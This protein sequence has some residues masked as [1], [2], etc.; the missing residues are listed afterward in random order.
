MA[1]VMEFNHMYSFPSL[2]V[3]CMG[4]GFRVMHVQSS[5]LGGWKV[6]DVCMHSLVM[7]VGWFEVVGKWIMG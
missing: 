2:Q 4:I 5:C 7:F 3:R 6:A 1:M